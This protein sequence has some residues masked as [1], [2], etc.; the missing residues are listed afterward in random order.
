MREVFQWMLTTLQ[1][2]WLEVAKFPSSRGGYT[3]VC[4]S[5]NAV[6]YQEFCQS[7]TRPRRKRYRRA[8]TIIKRQ[9]TIRALGRIIAGNTSGVYAERLTAMAESLIR[10]GN[11]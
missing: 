8:R 2:G 1:D 3:R 7:Y 9:E 11:T 10:D 6:W 5:V 4:I